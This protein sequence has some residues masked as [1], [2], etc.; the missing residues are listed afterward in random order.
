MRDQFIGKPF[1]LTLGLLAL[2]FGV[3]IVVF[4][5]A[6]VLPVMLVLM[7]ATFCIAVWRLEYGLAIA[8][9]ELFANSH[10][11]LLTADV[12][13]FPLSLRV[14]VFLS[15][16]SAWVVL[17]GLR[18]IRFT[19]TDARLT[20]F[21]VLACAVMLGFVQ[22]FLRNDHGNAFDDGN[23]YV[24]VA[25]ILPILSVSW[26]A[27]K[28]R[29][30][31]QV[32]AAAA[33]WICILTIGLVFI[34]SHVHEA[35]L[36]STYKFIRDTRTGELTKMDVGYFR[37]FIQAQLSVAAMALILSAWTWVNK[38]RRGWVWLSSVLAL[39]DAIMIASLS[40]S[41][42]FGLLTGLV[43]ELV[44]F[45]ISTKPKGRDFVR[46]TVVHIAAMISGMILFVGILA[47]PLP[48]TLSRFP[49]N[50]FEIGKSRSGLGSDDAAVSSR[51]AL[52]DPMLNEIKDHPLLG[53][54]FGTEIRYATS[55][56]RM[57][58]M[59]SKDGKTITTY[60]FEWGWL[61]LWLKVG[62][63]GLIAFVWL[64]IASVKGLAP[65]LR[66]EQRWLGIGFIAVLAMLYVTHIFSPYLNHPLG[67]GLLLFVVPFF[68]NKQPATAAALAHE[69]V[70]KSLVQPSVAPL[71]SE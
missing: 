32:F 48:E 16:M 44:L 42:W 13:G 7:I 5:T 14:A 18:K 9:A 51:K 23:A 11:H 2:V 52:L 36:V 62:I 49:L 21:L 47:F 53:Q 27:T 41:F 68:K 6:F 56:P 55:D 61:E 31:L 71:T 57:L 66:G 25:Y 33:T 26:D 29:L 59:F 40:R 28:Q 65:Y 67:L 37:V 8:F 22:G 15:V 54:G 39:C 63:P 4:K 24:L 38:N 58:S 60:A 70:V 17:I 19:F 20:P 1:W 64:F 10:G 50:I 35:L 34:F 30:L 69:P 45:F 46:P 43:V 12:H 3:S